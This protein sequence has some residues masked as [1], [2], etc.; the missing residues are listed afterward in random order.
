M[1][2]DARGGRSR[3]DMSRP[4]SVRRPR[5]GEPAG[6]ADQDRAEPLPETATMR[7]DGRVALVT[8]AGSADGIGYATARRLAELGA[9]VAIVS[10]TRRIHDR[11]GE[12]GVTGFVADLTDESE[13]GALADAVAEQLGDVEVLVNNAGLASRASPEVLRPVAQLTYDEWRGEID[14]NLT[15]AFLSSRAFISGM[16]ERGWGRIVNLAATAGPVNALPTEAAY[17]AAKAGVVGLTRALAMEMI[18]DGVTVNAVAP[19]IIHTAA[20][21]MVEI[22]QGLG[23]PVGRPGTPDE[24]AAAIAFLCSPAASYITGQML[25]VDGGNSVREAQFR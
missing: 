6:A 12:L 19:G 4:G 20:S 1:A 2:L 17:A 3:R 22:K 11:A 24:V 16:S 14:R 9:R 23:T 7:L 25:V 5:V 21:T 18:A 8:G 10:T 13:V 15:T